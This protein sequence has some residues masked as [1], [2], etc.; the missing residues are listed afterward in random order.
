MSFLFGDN[1]STIKREEALN[2]LVEEQCD[3]MRSRVL[4]PEIITPVAP[5]MLEGL[6]DREKS[7]ILLS[8]IGKMS[9]VKIGRVMGCTEHG[10]RCYLKRA[11]TKLRTP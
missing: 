9:N 8:V 3:D 4:Y 2:R 5:V 11:Y 1:V 6:T 10:V 7:A